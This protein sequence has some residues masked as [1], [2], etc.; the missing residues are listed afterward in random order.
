MVVVAEAANEMCPRRLVARVGG[1]TNFQQGG[2]RGEG[3]INTSPGV[4]NILG[5]TSC[6]SE[7]RQLLA[8]C[9]LPVLLKH[10]VLN[11]YRPTDIDAHFSS[12]AGYGSSATCIAH[13]QRGSALD[14]S[15]SHILPISEQQ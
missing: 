10:R 8:P 3:A 5:D 4:S 7:M 9:S 13:H 6:G 12:T 15:E 14:R 2:G 11:Q 1:P